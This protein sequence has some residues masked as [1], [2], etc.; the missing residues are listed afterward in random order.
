LAFDD[1]A[2]APDFLLGGGDMGAR[3]RAMDWA[4]T[5]LGPPEQ[6]PQSLRS[7]VSIL[8]P[9]RAQIVLFWGPDLVTL[10][11]DA[12]RPVFG[13]KHPRV[14]GLPAREA[15]SEI[16]DSTL[17]ELLEDVLRTGDAFWGKDLP[18]IL[19]RHG[20][21]EETFFDVSYDPV[22]DESGGVGGVFC[23]VSETTGRVV[24]ERRLDM[25]R[26]LAVRNTSARST[27]DVCAFA[28]D[29]FA[30]RPD[31]VPLALAYLKTAS[32]EASGETPHVLVASTPG[33]EAVAV[34]VGTRLS[35]DVLRVIELDGAVLP[36]SSV[37]KLALVPIAASGSTTGMLVV[38]LNPLRPFDDQYRTFLEL[39]SGQ[40]ATGIASARAYEQERQ[41]AAALAELD[42]AKTAFFSNVSHEFRTPLTLML[43]PLDDLV[44][45]AE[46]RLT[47]EDQSLLKL[48]RQNG[49]RLHKL[50]NTL[51][52][53]ARIEAG[54]AH[55]EYQP[56]DLSALT[57]DLASNFR[58]ACERA[59][60]GFEVDCGVLTAPAFVDRE[61]W[62]KIVLNLLSNAVKYTLKGSIAVTLRDT[63]AE[64]ELT[65]R[66]TGIGIPPEALPHVFER[67][68]RVEDA[69]GRSH[70]GSGIGLALVNELV[71]L[72]HGSLRVQSTLGEGS[73]FTVTVPKGAAH[74]PAE[75]VKM[76]PTG[77]TMRAAAAG[78][79]VAEVLGWLPASDSV[80]PR[81]EGAHRRRIV[82]ADDNADLREYARRL[83]AEEYVVDAVPDGVA[84]LEAAR[85]HRPDVVLSDVMMPRLDGFG[86]IRELRADPELRTVPVI[87]ISARAGEEAR[88]EGLG[89]GADDYLVKPFSSRELL[90]RVGAL[91]HARELLREAD[92]RKDEFLATLSHELRNPLAPLRN[93]IQVL[94][95]SAD[96]A[97]GAHR[98]HDLMERQVDHLTRLVDDLL[99]LSRITRGVLELRRERVELSGILRNAVETS[100]PLIVRSR[101]RL[102][103]SVP[104][105]SLWLEGDPVRLA[106]ILSNLLNNAAK[107]TPEGGVI[108]LAARREG[109]SV[110]I[111]VRD[112]GRGI[113][114]EA[115]SRIF[116]MFERVVHADT[117]GQGGLGIGLTLS[118]RLAEMHGGTIKARS[119]GE[120]RGSEFVVRLPLASGA[121]EV[122]PLPRASAQDLSHLRVLV[123]DDNF[124]SAESLGLL[125]ETF[126]AEVKLAHDGPSALEIF[127]ATLPSVVLLD[128]GMP[129][130][131]GYEVARTL[132]ARYPRERS[133]LVA[134]TGWGQEDDRKRARE[135]GFD[136]HLVKPAQVEAIKK[137]LSSVV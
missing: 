114:K 31:E 59:E 29:A 96:G 106:Q 91:V 97:S 57:R 48:V 94:R 46:E 36:A 135:A 136:H 115:L 113:A 118:R 128:I 28:I 52:D 50:V 33:C 35:T 37:R 127:A 32:A 1:S 6:W 95:L 22:R 74:L 80:P 109:S 5:P 121:P 105:E 76:N 86:L 134:L 27:R 10:Y 89:R 117:R 93:A 4:S 122:R 104:A 72:H 88:V 47:L 54:R 65:V 18:F 42:R 107:Y 73:T 90:V 112:N 84:A 75:R 131:D 78:P 64:L 12:Y 23:I 71:K 124:D 49:Q 102:E 63:G 8:L 111:S 123:V 55:V 14:L 100:E 92:S 13:A 137:L 120:G 24:G 85:A 101:H 20:F 69:R 53:F 30:G 119:D 67:F 19:E 133:T 56:T 41:R 11:N 58:S 16:W 68:R 108:T 26:D 34:A 103:L 60:L 7:A 126:G 25:L 51:L 116:A 62:E 82:L 77:A 40:L 66:D 43:G 132:R 17:R 98:V 99:E 2:G 61:M 3:M 38:G 15:W 70:E 39:V 83:L 87:L 81:T 129:E 79:Y 44:A 9:S 110:V 45:R 130:M 125:L 21:P